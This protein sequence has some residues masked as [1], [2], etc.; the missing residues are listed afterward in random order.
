[1][2]RSQKMN[3]RTSIPRKSLVFLVPFLNLIYTGLRHINAFLSTHSPFFALTVVLPLIGTLV[4]WRGGRLGYSVAVAVNL[5]FLLAEGPLIGPAISAVTLTYNFLI[6]VTAL[7]LIFASIVYSFLGLGQAWRMGAPSAARRLIPASSLIALLA[8]GFIIGG[9]VVGAYA[10]QTESRLAAN[11]SVSSPNITIVQGAG[12][13]SN[14][15]FYSPANYT[16][17]AGTTVTWVNR[18]G[19]TH[20]V[21]SDNGLFDSG[22]LPS[23]ASFSYTFSQPGVYHY[24]CNYHSWMTG[25][26]VVTSG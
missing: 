1:L 9:A 11:G 14:G 17:P 6:A 20:S 21:T 22:P 26:I 25:T 19:T 10:A 4:L 23:G 5:L 18:D 2:S 12:S 16:V 3:N 15:Q 13:S 8:L 7:P 24:S